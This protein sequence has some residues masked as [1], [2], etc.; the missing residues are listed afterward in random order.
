MF[1]PPF[2][3]SI[4]CA[5]VCTFSKKRRKVFFSLSARVSAS[6]VKKKNKL[7]LITLPMLTLQAAGEEN[8]A[9]AEAFWSICTRT[10]Y[11]YMYRHVR[12]YTPVYSVASG[13]L[14]ITSCVAS[15]PLTK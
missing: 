12:T 7:S 4:F 11:A 5:L 1:S 15:T 3:C 13:G 6:R 9:R 10:C 14:I 8:G 2:I